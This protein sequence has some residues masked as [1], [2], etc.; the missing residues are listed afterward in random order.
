[1][2]Y[3]NQIESEMNFDSVEILFPTFVRKK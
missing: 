2:I 1:V 3:L